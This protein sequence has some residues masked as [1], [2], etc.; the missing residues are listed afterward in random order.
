V[1]ALDH[2][3]QVVP[4]SGRIAGL[5]PGG[6]LFGPDGRYYFGSRRRRTMLA[7]PAALDGHAEALLPDDV[8]PFPRGFGFGS[9]R[10]MY[11]ASGI[12]PSGEGDN[13]ILVFDRGEGARGRRVVVDPELSPLDL[14]LAPNGNI[15]VSSERPFGAPDAVTSIREYDPATGDLVRVFAPDPSLEFRKPRGLRFGADD[16]IYCVGESH[17][18]AFD[19]VTG[20]FVAVAVELPRLNGQALLLLDGD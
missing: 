8:V 15:V 17:V 16:R 9:D 20:D 4:D 7:L 19:F 12:G 14:T 10:R 6:G 1:L 18:V 5:D 2:H 3:G 11:L 13:T